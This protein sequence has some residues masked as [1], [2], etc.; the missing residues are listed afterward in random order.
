MKYYLQNISLFTLYIKHLFTKYFLRRHAFVTSIELISY[1]SK[2][3]N[4]IANAKKGSSI[5][6]W[7]CAHHIFS[8]ANCLLG[9]AVFKKVRYF[10][11]IIRMN[12]C[13]MIIIYKVYIK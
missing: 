3:L 8:Y 1:K 6:H 9:N 7:S 4:T 2:L 5:K 12:A 10:T 13:H 11:N